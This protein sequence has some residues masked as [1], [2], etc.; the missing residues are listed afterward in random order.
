MLHILLNLQLWVKYDHKEL[1]FPIGC[2]LIKLY[3][4]PFHDFCLFVFMYYSFVDLKR[5]HV[6]KAEWKLLMYKHQ[7]NYIHVN[8]IH[9][10]IVNCKMLIVFLF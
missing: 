3:F 8:C 5:V 9:C 7:C 6:Y 4:I 2:I 1:F 10:D